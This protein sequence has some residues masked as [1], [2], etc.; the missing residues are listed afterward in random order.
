MTVQRRQRKRVLPYSLQ[1]CL[2][3]HECFD[4]TLTGQGN[5]SLPSL[6]MFPVLPPGSAGRGSNC[7]PRVGASR[8]GFIKALTMRVLHIGR[9][10][11]EFS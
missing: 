9:G 1:R 7:G 11:P 3:Q 6:L 10:L 8:S 4:L 5:R 2:P